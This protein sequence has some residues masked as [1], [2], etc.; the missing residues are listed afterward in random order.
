MFGLTWPTLQLEKKEKKLKNKINK[1]IPN[2]IPLYSL[3][4]AL[5]N[6]HQRGFFWQHKGTESDTQPDIM[7]KTV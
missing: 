3:I 2:D 6:H 1:M 7:K 4:S 5:S